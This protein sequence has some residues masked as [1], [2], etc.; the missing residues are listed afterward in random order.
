[1]V[2]AKQWI[3]NTLPV[4]G[5]PFDFNLHDEKS[6]FKLIE[7]E[8]SPDQLKDGEFLVETILTSNDP[9]QKFWIASVDK[10]YAKPT[11][12]GECIPA[13]GVGKVLASKSKSYQV[14]DYV[15]GKLC[16]TTHV[17]VSD[18]P[19]NLL[20][21]IPEKDEN[22]LWLYIS[23]FGGTGLTAY[24]IF[25]HYLG[26]QER[27]GD[28]GKTYLIS[29]A[30]GAVG[31]VCVQLALNVFNASKVI[32]IAGGSE[33]VKFVESFDPS[34]VVGVDYKAP[35]FK[36]DLQKAA[37]GINTVDYFVDNV[38]GQILD[39]GTHLLKVHGTIIACGSIS[40]YNNTANLVFK[41]YATVITKRLTIKGLLVTDNLAR[42]PEALKFLKSL[43]D[44]G[45]LSTKNAA[46]FKDAK[47]EN[48][49]NIPLIWDGLFH[50]SNKGKLIS[51]I[52]DAE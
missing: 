15:A 33:K 3:L 45:K 12:V 51:V 30:A 39:L 17:I 46:T 10:N 47:G 50:G 43:V 4:P 42:F 25:F 22:K 41:N 20:L 26:L 7:K 44:S 28:Y 9:A 8:L 31:T 36:E 6:T 48:F 40:G 2:K 16:W 27:E 13:R 34:R 11:Q 29:G 37:G 35:S 52:R 32:A 19:A 5:Q 21:K 23:L 38:G 18:D 24:F 14:G 49:K 1:M